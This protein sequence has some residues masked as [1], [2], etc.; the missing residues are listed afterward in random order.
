M[1]KEGGGVRPKGSRFTSIDDRLKPGQV[2]FILLLGALG[3]FY[4]WL[5]NYHDRLLRE[6][7]KLEVRVV[8]LRSESLTL[9]SDLM[10]LSKESAVLYQIQ[11]RG[12]RL[13]ASRRPPVAIEYK[14]R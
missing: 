5:R 10:R 11:A 7:Q 14:E 13:E 4:I 12:M 8:N 2:A 6:E 9:T 3:V 1:S